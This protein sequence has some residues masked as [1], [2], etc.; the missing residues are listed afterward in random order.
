MVT[1]VEP[2][3]KEMMLPS[4][5]RAK[6]DAQLT[7]EGGGSKIVGENVEVKGWEGLHNDDVLVWNVVFMFECEDDAS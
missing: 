2:I 7:R 1:D 4:E 5:G 3:L 6:A